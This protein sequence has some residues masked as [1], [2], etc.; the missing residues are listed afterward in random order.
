MAQREE[1]TEETQAEGKVIISIHHFSPREDDTQE[2]PLV[3]N[4]SAL[5]YRSEKD[6]AVKR[7][8]PAVWFTR[9]VRRAACR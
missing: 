2:V 3:K 6:Q 8:S 7:G 1:H 9:W 5:P 4:L